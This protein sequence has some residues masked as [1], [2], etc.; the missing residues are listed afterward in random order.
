MDADGDTVVLHGMDR[1][2]TEY[3]CVEGRGIFDGPSDQASI[4]AMR[5]RGPVNAVRVP[6]NEACWNGGSYVDI[7]SPLRYAMSPSAITSATRRATSVGVRP[8]VSM[9]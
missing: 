6:L 7:V 8:S 9:T 1:S 2:G 4:T 3:E 5:S